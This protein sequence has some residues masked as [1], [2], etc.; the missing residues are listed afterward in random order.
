MAIEL[1]KTEF[2]KA[3]LEAKVEITSAVTEILD[4]LHQKT[5]IVVNGEINFSFQ[6]L[7]VEHSIGSYTE[8]KTKITDDFD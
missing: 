6:S 8:L 2:D 4:K 5:G 1:S 7:K 3:C